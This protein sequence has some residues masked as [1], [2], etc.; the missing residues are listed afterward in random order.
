MSRR[1]P[2]NYHTGL[3]YGTMFHILRGR[4][5]RTDS[6]MAGCD[7]AAEW[8]VSGMYCASSRPR[9]H[10]RGGTL[11]NSGADRSARGRRRE[12][13]VGGCVCKSWTSRI[14]RPRLIGTVTWR[15]CTA[16]EGGAAPSRGPPPGRR[17]CISAAHHLC[18]RAVGVE[19][20]QSLPPW[21][22]TCAHWGRAGSCGGVGGR[23]VIP[24]R[25]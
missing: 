19:T 22:L 10:S 8:C 3:L 7:L 13:W 12:K 16:T 17:T 25:A 20:F 14:P 4:E 21:F 23:T 6:I 1:Y 9:P 24:G 18:K 11:R 15:V 2:H 5:V